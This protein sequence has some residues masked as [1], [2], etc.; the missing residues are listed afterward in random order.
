MKLK[1]LW[2]IAFIFVIFGMTAC[3]LRKD[4]YLLPKGSSG[5][6]VVVFA[7]NG[8]PP[9]AT[10]NNTVVYQFGADKLLITSSHLAEGKSQAEY[11]YLDGID[12]VKLLSTPI[13][14][15]GKVWGRRTF[16]TIGQGQVS[17]SGETF[18]IGSEAAFLIAGEN[19]FQELKAAAG[20]K[21]KPR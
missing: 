16:S 18:F 7:Q 8:W 5:W 10:T 14:G 13:G 19:E 1:I 9:L 15:G 21:L 11:C 4:I 3:N 6:F 12:R 2:N 20:T 17:L